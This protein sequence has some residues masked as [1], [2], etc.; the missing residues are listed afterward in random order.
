[1]SKGPVANIPQRVIIFS[2]PLLP[3]L[4]VDGCAYYMFTVG[5][6]LEACCYVCSLLLINLA[7][8]KVCLENGITSSV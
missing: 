5:L 8:K 6:L 4:L 2:F 1:M 3:I 7:Y